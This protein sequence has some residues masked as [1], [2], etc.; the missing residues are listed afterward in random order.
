MICT[1][2]LTK[3]LAVSEEGRNEISEILAFTAYKHPY[4]RFFVYSLYWSVLGPLFPF[5]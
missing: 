2:N 4:C 1:E 5:L 3:I